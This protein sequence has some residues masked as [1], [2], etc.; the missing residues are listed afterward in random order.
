MSTAKGRRDLLAW[1]V[2]VE[3]V[4]AILVMINRRPLGDIIL[5]ILMGAV[6]IVGLFA[7]FRG[8]AAKARERSWDRAR[9]DAKWERRTR[10]SHGRTRVYLV[11][12][13]RHGDET[14]EIDPA[15]QVGT[16]ISTEDPA[17][18]AVVLDREAQADERLFILNR[19]AS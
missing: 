10:T 18:A 3:L 8:T 4:L 19:S 11:R 1:T 17:W 15:E 2:G 7:L 14:R 16:A 5:M 9:E 12:V 6:A 13:A